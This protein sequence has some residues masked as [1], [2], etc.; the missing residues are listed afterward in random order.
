M[1]IAALLIGLLV[2][3]L[4]VLA[5]V[6]PALV[7]RR[8]RVQEVIELE[9]SLAATEAELRVEREAADARLRTCPGM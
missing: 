1:V 3:A 8:R 7:E 2:G 5:A 4:A 9:R 6:R